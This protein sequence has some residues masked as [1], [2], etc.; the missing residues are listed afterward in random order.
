[1]IRNIF[2]IGC[3]FASSLHAASITWIAQSP[4]NDMNDAAN[5]NPNTVPGAGD[6]AVFDSAVSGISTNP[7]ESSAPFSVT[8]FNF[9]NLASPF[10]FTFNN[11]NLTFSGIGITGVTTN[12]SIL[13]NNNNNAT[14][15]GDMLAFASAG[16]SGQA[17][18][19]CLNN[20]SLSGAQSGQSIGAIGSEIHAAGAYTASDEAIIIAL[21]L[22]TD[23]AT[24]LG[25]NSL[26]AGAASQLKFDDSCTLGDN[27][28]L[29]ALNLGEFGGSNSTTAD[30]VNIIQGNQLGT[31]GAFAVGD[32]FSCAIGNI[33]NDNNTGRGGNQ[34]G[35]INAAQVGLQTT[36][37]VGNNAS[38]T[39]ANI[40]SN[41]AATTVASDQVAYL[42]DNQFFVGQSLQA[43]DGFNLTVNNVGSDSSTG[44][45][46]HLVSVINS[47]S[48]I[49]GDQ[50]LLLRGGTIGKNAAMRVT[51]AG[52]YSGTNTASG[53]QVGGMNLGQCAVGDSTAIG[54]YNFNTGENFNLTV[55]NAG[56]DTATGIG[57][58]AVGDVSTNQL[59][60]FA[61]CSLGN[62][63]QINITSAG[64]YAG[65]ASTTYVNVGS[66][67]SRQL[68]A[69]STFLAGDDF[70]LNITN[71]G[72]N[73]GSGIGG[74]FIGDIITGQQA[75]FEH[76]CTVG[77]NA[78][79]TITNAGANTASTTN[80]NQVG[81]LMGF[82]VQFLVKEGFNVG[83]NL[84]L[85]ITNAGV[86]ESTTA[87]G[88]LVGFINNN[89]VD[90][91]ASQCHLTNGA[92]V[93]NNA[94]ITITN[95]G[96]F[97]GNNAG[98]NAIATFGG[99]AQFASMTPF[100]A[101][102]KLNF[103]VSMI[104]TSNASGQNNNR[105]A[106]L[107]GGG[108]S[109]IDFKSDCT[110]GNEAS[111]VISNKG[112]NNDGTGTNNL[113][114][115][116]T[117]A[118]L[119]VVGDFS[120]GN[121]LT[122][123]ISN[124]AKNA[125][126]ASNNVGFIQN[127]QLSFGQAC[128]FGDG[129]VINVTNT[130]SV[131][132]SQILFNQGFNL[133]SGKAFIEVTN[134]GTVTNHGIDVEGANQ[135][136]NAEVTL[137]NSSLYIAATLPTFTIGGLQGDA[138]STAQ[139]QPTLIINRDS[140]RVTDF[141]GII[142]DFSGSVPTLLVKQGTGTQ[143]L[144]G[145]NTYTGLT[146]IEQG[147]LMV[148]GSL[149]GDL[150]IDP[151]GTLKGTG[152]ISGTVTNTGT[153]APG[154]NS[155]GTITVGSYINNGGTYDVEVN[156]VANDLI[157]VLTTATLNGGNVLVSFVDN[158]FKLNAPYTIVTADSSLTG[159]FTRAISPGFTTAIL[160]YDPNNV[161]LTIKSD[162][163]RAAQRCNQLGVAENIDNIPT[164]SDAQSLLI[165]TIALLP[166]NEAQ[167]A[168][169]S[170]SGF[171]YTNE[172]WTTEIA[173]SRFI[174]RLYDPLRYQVTAC[175]NDE[176]E[177]WTT[178]LETGA[179]FAQ[180]NGDEAHC[181]RMFSY[182]VTAGLQKNIAT[183]FF[184][185]LAASY[186]YD[187]EKFTAAHANRN[188]AYVGLYGLYRPTCWYTLFDLAYGHTSS[189]VT[190][191]IAAGDLSYKAFGN[192]KVNSFAF[193][194][195]WGF[196]IATERI[197]AQPFIGIQVEKNWRNSITERTTSAW[198]LVIDKDQWTPVNTRL[199]L[200]LTACNLCHGINVSG[201]L[202]WNQRCTRRC[203]TT[204]GHFA[205]FGD[206]YLICGNDLDDSSIDYALTFTKCC[207]EDS[208]LYLQFEGQY[209][210]HAI[211]NGFLA[212][213]QYSW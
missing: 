123:N 74:F 155:I 18:I 30:Q 19:L 150:L 56:N 1:M 71:A 177:N 157:H 47:N 149:A 98:N 161:F 107:G 141:A 122:V 113:I 29:A 197:L 4:N 106:V 81:S 31:A 147:T 15:L 34:V 213:L 202:A 143:V 58:D 191:T 67:G 68:N 6:T 127:S 87:G 51:N 11:Q 93:G 35:V 33:G 128:T 38:I 163:L 130:G 48:G 96:T 117:N 164:L 52:I 204:E 32:N 208:K 60:F 84:T 41:A 83:D 175:C 110:V 76:G 63:A 78:S 159:K 111:F 94:S 26:A 10:G 116:V 176:C 88:N 174:R 145:I 75:D 171:Q 187:N 45:G 3:C 54:S 37:V 206:S 64:H 146:T 139:S 73:E 118:Q 148:N 120:A 144:S 103:N 40:G 135:G 114:G 126:D 189:H 27:I 90:F 184:L 53:C 79:I 109:Q 16:S 77:D 152:T 42:N 69:A 196:D 201:D 7:T 8:A 80:N 209:W 125:G 46:Q 82:G 119:A 198:G 173:T 194:A 133:T 39:I 49:T 9:P 158:T 210:N 132:G 195:E 172:V 112:I 199:G 55:T 20:V 50:L 65:S 160:T 25:G 193:Y 89:T 59:S 102:D 181:T 95:A 57:S 2:I 169:E 14:F 101:G 70:T 156:A 154:Q 12:T 165:S 5:W 22:G 85:K 91:V 212:G 168:L 105:I 28:M 192:P 151:A 134:N 211:T 170:L 140:S 100:Q 186:E 21:N 182:Q 180:V 86:D 72:S 183:N 23:N 179:N 188:A 167:E 99:G 43:G 104:G 129:S 207:G 92:T 13:V 97:A 203:N 162:L 166:L 153:I 36:G 200:H 17:N 131:G 142:Q 61:P 190:R 136:G 44:V 137:N 121:D 24:A 66:V 138:T 178:W 62:Q 185:G 205:G 124:S 108:S 115:Y